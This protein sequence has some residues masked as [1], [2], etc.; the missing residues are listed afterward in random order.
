MGGSGD[1]GGN[2]S[3]GTRR[4]KAIGNGRQWASEVWVWEMGVDLIT[5]RGGMR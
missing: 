5:D 4:R 1:L 3:T 2:S